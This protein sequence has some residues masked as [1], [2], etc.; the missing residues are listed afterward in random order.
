M[1]SSVRAS[2]SLRGLGILGRIERQVWNVITDTRHD[3]ITTAIEQ[4]NFEFGLLH[5]EPV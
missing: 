3:D 2:A 1:N 5:F 4:A